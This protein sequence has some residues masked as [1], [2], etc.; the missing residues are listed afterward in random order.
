MVCTRCGASITQAAAFCPNCGASLTAVP[1]SMT[2][3]G[4]MPAAAAPAT[5]APPMP[6][7]PIGSYGAGLHLS[8]A[9]VTVAYAGFWR[10]FWAL[11]LDG[12]V[13]NIVMIP[14]QMVVG[15]P[16]WAYSDGDLTPEG[17]MAL[18]SKFAALFFFTCLVQWIYFAFLE[19]SERQASLGK[20]ALGIKVTDLEGR[21]ISFGRATGRYFARFIT[22]CTLLI[23]YLM[24]IFTRRRQT[25]HDLI[26]GTLVVRTD[27]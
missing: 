3:A 20:M 2:P 25:L 6:G 1:A 16:M 10:R 8:A 21:R 4:T 13:M 11:L 17:F 5:S 9:P 7:A 24:Q 19:S 26:T 12:I 14:I 27:T 15:A 23:G 18:L 22:A